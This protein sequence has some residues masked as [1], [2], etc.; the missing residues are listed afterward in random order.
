MKHS[1]KIITRIWL[2]ASL[3]MTL[4]FLG[5]PGHTER[6]KLKDVDST[7]TYEKS[8]L[9]QSSGCSQNN[10]TGAYYWEPPYPYGVRSTWKTPQDFENAWVHNGVREG[11][12][13]EGDTVILDARRAG[14]DK[15]FILLDQNRTVGT[16]IICGYDDNHGATLRS[17]AG[18]S[19]TLTVTDRFEWNG[20]R[21]LDGTVIEAAEVIIHRGSLGYFDAS[22]GLLTIKRTGRIDGPLT[23]SRGSTLTVER[24]ATLTFAN[25]SPVVFDGA[26]VATGTLNVLGTAIINGTGGIAVNNM[27][28]SNVGGTLDVIKVSGTLDLQSDAG[29]STNCHSAMKANGCISADCDCGMTINA[30]GQLVKSAGAGASLNGLILNNS[31]KVSAKSGTLAFSKPFT[32]NAGETVLDGGNISLGSTPLA[33]NGG[34]LAGVGTVTGNVTNASIVQPGYPQGRAGQLTITGDYTQ[35]GK[36]EID[37]GGTTESRFDQLVVNRINVS[38]PL[39]ISLIN[40]FSPTCND[41]FDIVKYVT[42]EGQFSVV[43]GI[44]LSNGRSFT[45]D[46]QP[47]DTIKLV[48]QVVEGQDTDSDGVFDCDDADDD[49]DGDR[50][51]SDCAQIDPAIH[52]GAT[53]VC[54]G[55]DDDCDGPVDEGVTT[56]FYQDA[57]GDGYGNAAV[58][59][60][61][62]S[63][64]AG[65]VANS[66]DCNDLNLSVHPGATEVCDGIDNDCGGQIDEGVGIT[67][68]RDADND[69]Y[70]D[71]Q[72][73]TQ[74]CSAPAGYVTNSGDCDDARANVNPGATEVCDG[75]DNDCDGQVDEGV[76]ITFYRDA[77]GDDFGNPNVSTTACASTPPSDYVGNNSDC[78][79]TKLLYA[80]NDGDGYGAGQPVACGVAN[81]TDCNDNNS[82]GHAPRTYYLDADGDGFGNPNNSTSICSSTAPAGYVANNTDCND[83]SAA[84]HPGA[85]EI[86]DGLDNDCDSSIDE[87]SPNTDADDKADCADTDD[88]NDG[89]ADPSDNCPLIR[90]AD[91][92]NNDRDS[93]GDACDPDDDN[94]GGADITDCE[95]FIPTIHQFASEVCNG[96]DDDCDGAVD[97]GL[98][99]T[100]YRDADG[101]GYGNASVIAQRCTLPSGYVANNVDCNDSKTSVHPNATEICDGFDNDCDSSIDEGWTN[102]DADGQ[103]DC[104]DTD[105]DNDGLADKA[106]NCPLV[107]NRNQADSNGDGIG[108]VCTVEIVFESYRDGNG[109]IYGM[110]SDG[111]GVVRLTNNAADDSDPT[112]SQDRTKIAFVSD[113]DGNRE[114]Y[115]M[116]L[117]NT[118]LMRLTTNDALDV[119]PSWSPD[120]SMLVFTS[121]RDGN[122]EIYSMD[123][124][125]G[126]PRNLTNN[127]RM[128]F[129]PDWG[130]NGKIAFVSNRDGPREIYSM[131]IDGSD[132]QRLTDNA[133]EDSHPSWA[134]PPNDKQIVFTSFRDGNSEI[135]VM[136]ADGS[137]TQRQT[138]NPA[139]DTSPAWG[140]NGEI[141]FVSNRDGNFEIYSMI[142][143]RRNSVRRLTNQRAT[144]HGPDW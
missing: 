110:R 136:K 133:V 69:G 21:I 127:R 72:N 33:L 55:L 111:T 131:D 40:N 17:T 130:S 26:N 103:A 70:G 9:L 128:D 34:V 109:E 142:R 13:G 116:N 23:V 60:Q 99:T 57:D 141:A 89:W 2:I 61:A 104:A 101:D 102:T 15:D 75:L 112:L 32:Q 108:D 54:N 78:D 114:I 85:T 92:A 1:P 132:V 88:D 135:Y 62:C 134:P 67:F 140:A 50:D 10:V 80:D 93:F 82:S 59:T 51:D 63:A 6:I 3:T 25:S 11:T 77:D 4:T 86:C 117:N 24:N 53:E 83:A 97:E 95:P 81:N 38:G 129:E 125:G 139:F 105:D 22:S 98:L 118:G 91:Q 36:L 120:G 45:P 58:T 28:D 87:G 48:A 121:L 138:I 107:S 124:T 137:G 94:D 56:T 84:S 43:N 96:V 90:N 14:A 52:H 68:Y 74:S 41:S 39:D 31:G 37:I 16:L 144:D 8:E 65:N 126:N 49:N 64:P 42:R 106:D 47:A 19:H 20:G 119:G 113:R 123:A 44:N 76:T 7:P 27:Y 12:P 79:D 122:L 30:G 100:F 46:Y 5:A 115:S 18:N 73:S 29:L 35:T 143:N 66:S 71:A